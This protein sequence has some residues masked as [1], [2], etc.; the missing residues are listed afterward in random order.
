MIRTEEKFKECPPEITVEN[1]IKCLEKVD[2]KLA[3]TV[4]DAKIGDCYSARV[5]PD[6]K[7]AIG[8]N[9]KGVTP[10]LARA[11]GYAEFIERLQCGL[12]LYKFQSICRDS[13]MCLHTYAPDAK[14]MTVDELI[15]NGEWMDYVI[16]TYCGGLTRKKLAEQCRMY[17]CVDEPN[18]KIL[19][20]P[21]YSLFEDKYIYLPM[22]Y[23]ETMYT[24]NGCCAGNSRDEAWVHALSEMIERKETIRVF[25]NDEPAPI[26]PEDVI[27]Q[28]PIPRR[29]LESVKEKGNFEITIYDFSGDTGYPV[30]GTLLINKDA[31]DYTLN[32]SAD[33]LLEIALSRGLTEIL[34]G[35]TIES[36]SSNHNDKLFL[37]DS[38]TSVSHNLI[39]QLETG[40][41][42]LS[43]RY[44]TESPTTT[45]V[46]PDN[47]TKTNAELLQY[48][49]KIFKD[50]GKPVYVRNYSFLGFHTYKFV[51]PGYSETRGFW[52]PEKIQEYGLGDV[53]A[54]VLRNPTAADII[55]LNIALMYFSKMQDVFSRR[56]NFS[57][58]AGLPMSGNIRHTLLYST[59]AFAAYKLGRFA[60]ASKYIN[61]ALRIRYADGDQLTIE[62][63]RYLQ[64]VSRYLDLKAKK[65]S[66]DQ[67][68]TLLVKLFD[69]TTVETFCKKLESGENLFEEFLLKCDTKNCASCVHSNI[70]SYSKVKD[71]IKRSGEYYAKFTDGQNRENFKI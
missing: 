68:K 37:S 32:V 42:L 26:I 70:C 36:F 1:I 62:Q 60:D 54:K 63:R 15:E 58:L 49:L 24:A 30:I 53:T 18:G 11:S 16:D 51:V 52:I 44:F 40:N 46:F 57:R 29:I 27:N 14:Y 2:I 9:G 20:L 41:G 43:V 33:P 13:E 56:D 64:I 69:K 38:S 66:T 47:S 5:E 50:M 35:Q 4:Y 23:V 71:M 21:F 31:Q 55:D 28:Y 39:N 12:W 6:N 7:A 67:I 48:A 65:I 22:G 3:E 8:S 61:M 17:A 59:M 19:T 45:T 10:N 25:A 34:Q